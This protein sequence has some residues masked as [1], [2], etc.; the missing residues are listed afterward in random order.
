M[1]ADGRWD[2]IWRLKGKNLK[3]ITGTLHEE[4][5]TFLIISLSVLLR[6]RNVTDKSFAENQNTYF[7]SY[8]YIY[9][10]FSFTCCFVWV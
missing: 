2:L 10:T 5:N 4:R 1:P 8:I 3:T 6:M 9:S 7:I